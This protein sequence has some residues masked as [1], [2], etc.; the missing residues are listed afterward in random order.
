MVDDP[1]ELDELITIE[2][3]QTSPD[4]SGGQTL[5]WT[6]LAQAWAKVKPVRLSEGERQ[7][8]VRAGRGYL[9]TLRRRTDLDEAMRIQW[10]GEA[11]NIREIR[12]PGAR[13]LYM[14]IMAQSGVTQ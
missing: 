14:E 3:Q 10:N 12:L 13:A 2:E 6:T 11:F 8:A 1:G 5:S 4:G 7:G 9:F